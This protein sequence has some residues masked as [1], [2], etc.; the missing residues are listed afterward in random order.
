MIVLPPADLANYLGVIRTTNLIYDEHCA[1]I[2]CRA[3]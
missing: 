1:N 2:I 3:N